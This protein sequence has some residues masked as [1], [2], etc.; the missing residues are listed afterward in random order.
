MKYYWMRL[1]P[2]RVYFLSPGFDA[3][4]IILIVTLVHQLDFLPYAFL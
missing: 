2:L 4:R 1:D 3:Y